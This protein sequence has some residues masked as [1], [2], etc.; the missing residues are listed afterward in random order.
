MLKLYIAFVRPI[1][2]YVSFVWGPHKLKEIEML[3]RVQHFALKISLKR[4]S[5]HYSEKLVSAELPTLLFH[6][7]CARVAVLYKILNKL[8]DF[9]SGYIEERTTAYQLRDFQRIFKP[10]FRPR[11]NEMFHSFFPSSTVT[12]TNSHFPSESPLIFMSLEGNYFI[13]FF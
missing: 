3:E 8:I 9:P 2:E 6:R 4:W 11:T 10:T 1:L 5:G 13:L 12:S 7:N